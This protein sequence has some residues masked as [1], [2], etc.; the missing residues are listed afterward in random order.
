[1][2]SKIIQ[3]IGGVIVVALGVEAV[4]KREVRFSWWS[5]D[6]DSDGPESHATGGM[7]VLIGMGQIAMGLTLIH[8]A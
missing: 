6:D 7:A 4:L 5:R 8:Y 3:V 1:M 2:D